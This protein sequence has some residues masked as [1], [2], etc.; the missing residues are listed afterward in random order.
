[1]NQNPKGRPPRAVP[2]YHSLMT[3]DSGM[4][5]QCPTNPFR[6]QACATRPSLQRFISEDPIEFSGG[7]VNLYAYA[8]SSPT[9][10]IDPSGLTWQTNSNFFWD[11]ALGLPGGG[12]ANGRFYGPNDIETQEMIHSPGGE[13]FRNEFYKNHCKNV[14]KFAYGTYEAYWDTAANPFTAD[15]SSTAF[16]VGGF[17]GAT[18]INNGNG[19]VTFQ[20]PNTAGTHSFFLHLVPDITSPTGPMHNIE[21]VFWW[22]E[23]IDPGRNCGCK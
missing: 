23:P 1:M 17:A 12:A 8:M 18:A 13:K 16:Q 21:Q 22:T 20:I 2:F 11:W 7:D 5:R 19:T 9:N 4:L 6:S 14:R 15:L 3:Y 10:L